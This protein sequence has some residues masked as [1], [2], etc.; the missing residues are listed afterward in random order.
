MVMVEEE[1]GS[2]RRR[3]QIGEEVGRK[4]AWSGGGG[5]GG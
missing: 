2:K 4:G 3:R 5:R 1:E